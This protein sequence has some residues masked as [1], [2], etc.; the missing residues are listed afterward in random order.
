MS[1][2]DVRDRVL[3]LARLYEEV[4]ALD[5]TVVAAEALGR[6]APG[7]KLPPGLI[8]ILDA[9]EV[10]SALAAVDADAVFWAHDIADDH[11]LQVPGLT[12]ARLRFVSQHVE[13]F[14]RHDDEMLALAFDDDLADRLRE[15]RRLSRRGTKVIRTGRRCEEYGCTGKLISPLG[16]EG[17][18]K[19]D[20]ALICDADGRH[21]VPYSVWSAWPRARV[22][23][24]TVEHAARK[25]ETTVPAVK[26]RASRG[27]W[28]RIG[29]GRDVRYD[30]RDVNAAADGDTGEENTA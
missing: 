25:L 11:D 10:H 21:Q 14:T 13:H 8:E 5:L 26:M 29:T 19:G 28:R 24:I 9:E 22:R 3:D 30:V 18:D 2:L 6:P 17:S 20:T 4:A 12:A 7:S 27:K 1:D 23:Y 16:R 15:M